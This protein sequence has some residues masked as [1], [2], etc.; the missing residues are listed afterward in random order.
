MG[1]DTDVWFMSKLEV[2]PATSML[3]AAE[4][5]DA[6]AAAA[7]ARGWLCVPSYVVMRMEMSSA[8]LCTC[9]RTGQPGATVQR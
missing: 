8:H 6:I 2:E 4:V 7:G 3:A 1:A 5:V 9:L